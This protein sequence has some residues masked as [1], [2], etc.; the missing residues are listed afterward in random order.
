MH[1]HPWDAHLGALAHKLFGHLR[2]GYND[3]AVCFLRNRLQVRIAGVPLDG[4]DFEEALPRQS[5][6]FNNYTNHMKV[7]YPSFGQIKDHD[8]HSK[9][10][11][12]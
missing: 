6:P 4:F 9:V 12:R 7:W 3:Q 1:P 8:T 11:L 10:F 5:S 2:P